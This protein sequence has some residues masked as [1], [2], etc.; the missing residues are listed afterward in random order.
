MV[1]HVGQYF[2][3]KLFCLEF[4]YFPIATASKYINDTKNSITQN[5]INKQDDVTELT[6]L[7]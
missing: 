3:Y 7:I 2:P 1:L 5:Q 4:T 6:A